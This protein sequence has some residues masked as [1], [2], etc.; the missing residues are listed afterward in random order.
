MRV[1]F[2]IFTL[3]PA[4]SLK[5]EGVERSLD[6]LRMSGE[7]MRLPRPSAEELA[8]TE[9]RQATAGASGSFV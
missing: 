9:K 4:L 1:C 5:G 6:E 3:T 8:M 2:D 7:L